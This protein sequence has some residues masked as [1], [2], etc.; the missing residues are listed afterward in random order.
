VRTSCAVGK[1]GANV[2]DFASAGAAAGG[3]AATL[4]AGA[5]ANEST[6][7]AAPA[8]P[9]TLATRSNEAFPAKT[10]ARERD[11]EN[12]I[13]ATRTKTAI[14]T[15]RRVKRGRNMTRLR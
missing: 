8:N 3:A 2:S 5:G 12:A 14:T 6:L 4:T 9:A 7:R 11:R 1:I 15:A 10:P 13:R